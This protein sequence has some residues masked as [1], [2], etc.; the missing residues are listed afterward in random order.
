MLKK[1]G[2]LTIFFIF[3]FIIIIAVFFVASLGKEEVKSTA[4]TGI[5]QELSVDDLNIRNFAE[6]C[7]EKTGKEALFYLGFVG[8]N[9]KPDAFALYYSFDDEYKVPYF[10]IEGQNNIPIPYDENYWTGLLDRYIINN[11]E[12][13]INKFESFEGA[14]IEQGKVGSDTEFTD[15]G[16]IF[17]VNF[18]VTTIREFK[19]NNLDPQ[20]VDGIKVRLRDI[21]K[22]ATTIVEQEVKNDKYIHWDY[23]TEVSA[24]NYN[25]TA[26]TEYNSTIVYRIIDLGNKIDDE[27]YVFEWANKIGTQ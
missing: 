15:D 16:V 6:S 18:P 11:L 22:I 23:L 27:V 24:R 14:D 1:R 7:V 13:C 3:L 10:Y 19:S 4:G 12:T 25:I 17:N 5:K 8:G 26:F 9:L 2:Q 21:L 20:Y